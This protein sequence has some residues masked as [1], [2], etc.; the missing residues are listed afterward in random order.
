MKRS[1]SIGLLAV[2]I[3]LLAIGCG[4]TGGS[5]AHGTGAVARAHATAAYAHAVNIQAAD[6]PGLTAEGREAQAY[7]SERIVVPFRCGGGIVTRSTTIHSAQFVKYEAPRLGVSLPSTIVLSK[8]YLAASADRAAR[9]LAADRERRVQE[10]A[11]RYPLTAGGE[12]GPLVRPRV[13]I[14]ELALRPPPGGF[15]FSVAERGLYQRAQPSGALSVLERA[16]KRF[17]LHRSRF[18]TDLLGFAYG[19]SEVTLVVL[20]PTAVAPL[21]LERRLLALLYAR[22]RAHAP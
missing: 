20:R 4:G 5:V 14:S 18:T 6:L 22:A 2:P 13:S 1:V 19:R 12:R 21:A 7:P 9:E 15:A 11:G 16:D 10:C 17:H 3:G 8:V